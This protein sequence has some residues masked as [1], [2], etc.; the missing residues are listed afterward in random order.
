M[1]GVFF[2]VALP[3][4]RGFFVVITPALGNCANGTNGEELNATFAH[5]NADSAIAGSGKPL[6]RSKHPH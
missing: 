1:R 2:V 4:L 3:S 5:K 6:D